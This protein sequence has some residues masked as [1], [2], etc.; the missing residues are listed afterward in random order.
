MH[1]RD[2]VGALQVGDCLRYP[3]HLP[4]FGVG[5]TIVEP[6]SFR[7]EFG[8][9]SMDMS[10]GES[11]DYQALL[12]PVRNYLQNHYHGNEPGDPVKAAKAML[13]ALDTPEPPTRLVLGKD[14]LEGV[15]KK[16]HY[17]TGQLDAWE[18]LSIST[19]F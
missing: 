18:H 3:K 13:V 2:L 8:A 9:A 17:V 5:I 12:S 10:A 16:L 19:D 1:L 15:R 11:S 14:A 4:Q 7:T 6:G